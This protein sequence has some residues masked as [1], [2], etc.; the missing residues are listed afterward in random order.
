MPAGYAAPFPQSGRWKMGQYLLSPT[1]NPSR[2]W[3]WMNLPASRYLY[4]HSSDGQTPSWVTIELSLS[5]CMDYPL[6]GMSTQTWKRESSKGLQLRWR[7]WCITRRF[8]CTLIG[9]DAERNMEDSHHTAR[10][11]DSVP[12]HWIEEF[13]VLPDWEPVLITAQPLLSNLWLSASIDQT[14][15]W[16]LI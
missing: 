13:L 7:G 8:L 5:T 1:Q 6:M 9:A 16:T 12:W 15:V 10:T 11:L 3:N 14:S 4:L 2:S